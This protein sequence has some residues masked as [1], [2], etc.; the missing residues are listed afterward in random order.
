MV[1]EAYV[2]FAEADCI[3]LLDDHP[4]VIV[5]RSFSK[6]Y[7]LAGLRLGYLMARPEVVAGLNKVK[8]SYNCDALSLAGGAAAL[9]DRDYLAGT[10]GKIL[11]TR[12][13]LA[14]AARALGYR[15]AE[16]RANFVWCTDGPPA[17]PIYE[18]LKD[19]GILVR[20]MRY[21]GH[22]DGLRG[23]RRDRRRDR[24][25]AGDLESAGGAMIRP[26]SRRD[27]G[28]GRPTLGPITEP[29]RPG[30]GVPGSPRPGPAP[31]RSAR[32]PRARGR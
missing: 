13:R 9:E 12:A 23:H 4:N 26:C 11:A 24:P 22:A 17:A 1:D 32:R 10:R 14:G 18:A 30:A 28:R 29:D 20:L 15:V 7:G 31:G 2:D 21:P 8:D 19:R 3:R 6:G 27:A 16:T 5:T 25:I